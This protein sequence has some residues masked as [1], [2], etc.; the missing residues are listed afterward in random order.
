MND[1]GK[2]R[3]QLLIE[4]ALLRQRLT[5][6]EEEVKTRAKEEKFYKA[7][8]N[9]PAMMWISRLEDGVY[10]DINQTA[11]DKLG[12]SRE[13]IIGQSSLDMGIWGTPEARNE[14]IHRIETEGQIPFIE[15]ENCTKNGDILQ[16]MSSIDIIEVNNQLCLIVILVDITDLKRMEKEINHLDRL[17]LIGQMAAS[18]CHEIRNPMTAVRGFLQMLGQQD[19]FAEEKEVFALM[20][21]ELD[22][23]NG[24]LSNYLSLAG[25]K[26]FEL[27]PTSLNSVLQ[28][29]YP[30]VLSDAIIA[31]KN[32]L[33]TLNE[34]PLLALDE[35]EIRQLILNLAR[36]GLE[37]MH[38]GGML[39]IRTGRENG[40]VLLEVEDQGAGISCE[41]L[42][43][44]GTPF[45]TTKSNGTG[46]G[47]PVCY[48]IAHRHNA[49][50]E[51]ETGTAGT[52]FKVRFAL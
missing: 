22:R 9:S 21:E 46:L 52:T 1:E 3:G 35:K 49:K 32:V 19:K 44:L 51:V 38:P 25:N 27:R 20:I 5:A 18:I 42:E 31:D 17:H 37:A 23:A 12:Y 4:L 29:I 45:Q 28:N 24:I 43:I 8:H 30:I 40:A 26:P 50:I 47:L 39:T 34:V 36:N 10:I 11:L 15:L 13:E 16:L 6:C 33:L 41:Q 2:T 7:F 48:S 14:L